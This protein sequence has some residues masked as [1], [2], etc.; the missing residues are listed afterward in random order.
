MCP[1]GGRCC[2]PF[3]RQGIEAGQE[4]AAW[5]RNASR[6][7]W[8]HAP[9]APPW[10]AQRSSSGHAHCLWVSPSSRTLP[11]SVSSLTLRPARPPQGPWHPCHLLYLLFLTQGRARAEAAPG[12]SGDPPGIMVPPL[13]VSSLKHPCYLVA[14]VRWVSPLASEAGLQTLRSGLPRGQCPRVRFCSR[15][16]GCPGALVD[17]GIE[18]SALAGQPGKVLIRDGK[19]SVPSFPSTICLR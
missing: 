1:A 3:H 10:T 9:A 13:H 2:G 16:W 7:G 8:D 18:W 6:R 12:P 15:S 14:S 4:G 19:F 11:W 5:L 17:T